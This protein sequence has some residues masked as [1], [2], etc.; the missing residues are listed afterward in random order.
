[1]RKV[2]N[3]KKNNNFNEQF[4]LRDKKKGYISTLPSKTA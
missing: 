3:T 4:C 1:M 2:A